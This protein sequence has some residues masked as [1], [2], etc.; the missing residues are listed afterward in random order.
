[1][2]L[3]PSFYIKYI[4]RKKG[5]LS[6][7]RGRVDKLYENMYMVAEDLAVHEMLKYEKELNFSN[8]YKEETFKE[9]SDD[10]DEE[11]KKI[12]DYRNQRL[13]FHMN[14]MKELLNKILESEEKEKLINDLKERNKK[15][16]KEKI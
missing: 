4:P 5:F 8:I 9:G 11:N 15:L 2:V 3:D 14:E 7:F 12:S 10:I 13:E 6:N 16:E 1:M